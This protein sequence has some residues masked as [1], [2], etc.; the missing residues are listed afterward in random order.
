MFWEL[1]QKRK[2]NLCAFRVD[3]PNAAER[4]GQNAQMQNGTFISFQI[5]SIYL[6]D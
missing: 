3:F 6:N 4:D 2:P 1:E 5:E